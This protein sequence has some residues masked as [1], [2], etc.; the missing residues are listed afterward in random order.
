VYAGRVVEG[1]KMWADPIVD[2]VW[3]TR[4]EIEKERK[5]DFARIYARALEVQKHAGAKLVSPHGTNKIAMSRIDREGR[6]QPTARRKGFSA[7][8]Q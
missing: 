1:V 6:S 5:E 2:E 4:L 7:S 8:D 3:R